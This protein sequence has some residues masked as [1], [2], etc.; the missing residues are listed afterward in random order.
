MNTTIGDRGER[1]RWAVAVVALLD[2]PTLASAAERSGVPYG[3]LRRWMCNPQFRHKLNVARCAAVM[4]AGTA[5]TEATGHAVRKLRGLLDCGHPAVELG[6]ANAIL[7]QACKYLDI[8]AH[9][10][11]LSEIEQ[12]KNKQI[13]TL[14]R[15]L[16]DTQRRLQKYEPM[17]LSSG[18]DGVT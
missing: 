14:G 1:G 12:L 3:T 2:A 10:I 8:T 6:A 15:Q 9:D 17:Q 16:A 13:G 5:L 4:A 7:N 11:R 18:E